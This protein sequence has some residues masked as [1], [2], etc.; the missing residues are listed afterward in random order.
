MALT[1][2]LVLIG[3][4]LVFAPRLIV[5][6]FAILSGVI[7]IRQS[8]RIEQQLLQSASEHRVRQ[9]YDRRPSR[10]DRRLMRRHLKLAIQQT[11][12]ASLF[13]RTMEQARSLALPK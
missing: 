5:W 3:L 13:P 10:S 12:L 11:Q 7:L 9:A 2:A 1:V 6:V 8:R 4:I